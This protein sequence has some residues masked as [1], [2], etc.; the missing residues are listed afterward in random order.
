DE[1]NNDD[2]FF[3]SDND[4]SYDS[5]SNE[6]IINDEEMDYEEI[7]MIYEAIDSEEMEMLY[8]AMNDKGMYDAIKID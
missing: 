6:N 1:P 7:E 5:N 8:E 4:M 2:S 3:V